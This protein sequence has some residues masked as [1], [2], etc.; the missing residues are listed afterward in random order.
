MAPLAISTTTATQVP[1]PTIQ[2]AP[3]FAG[4][5][6]LSVSQLHQPIPTTFTGGDVSLLGT[7]PGYSAA[8]PLSWGSEVPSITV[9]ATP[10]NPTDA[11]ITGSP[12]IV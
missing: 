8:N 7:D 10:A 6:G 4:S 2:L 11:W 1:A 12:S 9:T 5:S 3:S